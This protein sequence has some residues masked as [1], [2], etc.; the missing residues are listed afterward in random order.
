MSTR[1]RKPIGDRPMTTAERKARSRAN[2][3]GALR[4]D[5]DEAARLAR[6][7]RECMERGRPGATDKDIE[8]GFA[9]IAQWIARAQLNVPTS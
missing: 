8:S 2:I 3:L 7:W 4:V 5:L 6:D 1:G 9:E